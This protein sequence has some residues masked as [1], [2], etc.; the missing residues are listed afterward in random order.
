MPDCGSFQPLLP[1]NAH[2]PA[3]NCH[4]SPGES[5]PPCRVPTHSETTRGKP[6]AGPPHRSPALHTT[7][8]A[9]PKHPPHPAHWP[10]SLTSD[11][12]PDAPPCSPAPDSTRSEEHTSELQS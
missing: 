11:T 12:R 10:G 2:C 5:R 4:S 7:D 8:V 1:Q 3:R 9:A 6:L